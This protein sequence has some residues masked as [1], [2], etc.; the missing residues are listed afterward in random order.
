M[1]YTKPAARWSSSDLPSP[2]FAAVGFA[3]SGG[4]ITSTAGW[5]GRKIRTD[6]VGVKTNE[7]AYLPMTR[8]ALF[9]H[10]LVDSRD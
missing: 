6:V 4:N 2:P 5:A 9:R 3:F 7:S 10:P 1:L 8:A